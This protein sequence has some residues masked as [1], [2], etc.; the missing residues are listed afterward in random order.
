MN[1]ND[2]VKGLSY[3]SQSAH[4]T[5]GTERTEPTEDSELGGTLA[6]YSGFPKILPCF[7]GFRA[8]YALEILGYWLSPSVGTPPPVASTR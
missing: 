5:E 3:P 7:R 8:I 4:S 6:A 1:S 2:R